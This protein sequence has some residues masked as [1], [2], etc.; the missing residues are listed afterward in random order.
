MALTARQQR[1]LERRSAWLLTLTVISIR[2]LGFRRTYRMLDAAIPLFRRDRAGGDAEAHERL[3][4]AALE[5]ANKRRSLFIADCL[6]KSLV[7]WWL[8]CTS[9]LAAEFRLGARVLGGSFQ[10]HAW[11]ERNGRPLNEPSN[12]GDVY[13]AFD[14][15]PGKRRQA[16]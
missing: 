16:R 5:S 2:C 8:L 3:L 15:P 11:V 9:G 14:L 10:A 12:I 1:K 7:L 13:N 4:I 6:P